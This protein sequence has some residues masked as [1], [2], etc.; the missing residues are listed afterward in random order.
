MTNE[1]IVFGFVALLNEALVCDSEA[2]QRLL[3]HRELCNRQL[4][5]HP[6]VQVRDETETTTF[7]VSALGLINGVCQKLTGQRICAVV[8]NDVIIRFDVWIPPDD[9]SS[10]K[11]G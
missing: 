9:E 6:T 5:D 2:T 4:A 10:V 8:D 7:S 3:R 1:E 11:N